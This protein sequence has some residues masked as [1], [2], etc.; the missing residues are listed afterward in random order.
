MKTG[1]VK[2]GLLKEAI[3][4]VST[5]GL[6]SFHW[7]CCMVWLDY[8]RPWCKYLGLSL[9]GSFL[10]GHFELLGLT[11]ALLS[12]EKPCEGNRVDSQ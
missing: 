2:E 8:R 1:A 4:M 10:R 3:L 5:E 12:R 6:D 11:S 7:T 9:V